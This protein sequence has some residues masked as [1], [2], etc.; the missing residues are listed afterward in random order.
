MG[1]GGGVM[2]LYI[3]NAFSLG[4][5]SKAPATLTVE[6][7]DTESVRKIVR[8]FSERGELVSAVGHE[9]TASLLSWILG[10]DVAYNRVPIKLANG[11]AV[12]VFQLLTRL[13]EG[14]VLTEAELWNLK[15]KFY[16][17]RVVE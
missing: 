1:R 6:E 3:A 14:K 17:V 15:Y 16:L 10:E 8:T 5:L 13:E 2:T 7:L 12:I 4:M 11:D 9:A